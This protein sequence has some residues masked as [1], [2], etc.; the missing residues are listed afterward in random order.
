MEMY[1]PKVPALAERLWLYDHI[2]APAYIVDRVRLERNASLLNEI[3]KQTGVR[4]LLALKGFA[5]HGA[6]PSIAPSM[7]GSSASGLHE[8]KL[9]HELFGGE[10]HVYSPAYRKGE[11]EALLTMVDHLIFN[12]PSQW[13]A[14]R[15][16]I[17]QTSS[18]VS[19]GLRVNPGV[20][21]VGVDI[22][23]PCGPCS[24]LGATIESIRGC[25]LEGIDG[26]HFHAL[27]EQGADALELVLNVFETKFGSWL[28]RMKWVNLGGGHHITRD[29]YDRGKLIT[30]L[31]DFQRRYPHL[32]VYLEPGE[33]I[34]LGAG[35]LL[36][37]VLDIVENEKTI[38]I[39]D[40]SATCHMPDVLEMPYRPEVAGAGMPGEKS[41][42]YLLAGPSCLAG[43]QIGEYS[44]DQP[45]QPGDHLLFLDMAHYTM[46]KNTTFNGVPLPSIVRYHSDTNQHEVLRQFGY[47]DYKTRLS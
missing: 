15:E 44:F 12:S 5:M 22:Y 42:S 21:S 14:H 13:E 24:R 31:N 32:T 1:H 11:I 47:Q 9:G 2:E 20:S 35:F 25:S 39:L 41:Y 46:V 8:A 38:A 4:I 28:P 3:K 34:A 36:A 37:T 40:V 27:C 16:L 26:L 29:E 6:F 10:T 19:I 33:A 7:N 30:M 43:D 18:A 45:L 17:S 23:N